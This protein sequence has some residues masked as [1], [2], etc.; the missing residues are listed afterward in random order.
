MQYSQQKNRHRWMSSIMLIILTVVTCSFQACTSCEQSSNFSS[1]SQKI[2]ESGGGGDGRPIESKPGSGTYYHFVP[3]LKCNDDLA[4]AGAIEVV[5]STLRYHEVDPTTCSLNVKE[6]SLEK[7]NWSSLNPE[8]LGHGSAIFQRQAVAPKNDPLRELNQVPIAESWCRLRNADHVVDILVMETRATREI[9]A[10]VMSSRFN[11][12]R[13]ESARLNDQAITRESDGD[14]LLYSMKIGA[15]E[16][17]RG[18]V[19]SSGVSRGQLAAMINGIRIEGV[20]DCRVGSEYD[21]LLP[22]SPTFAVNLGDGLLPSGL[23]L[24]RGSSATYFDVNGRI[25]VAGANSARMDFNPSTRE[26]RG[27]LLEKASTNLMLQ[28]SDWTASPWLADGMS[29]VRDGTFAGLDRFRVAGNDP[30]A[31]QIWGRAAQHWTINSGQAYALT[32]F[33][34]RGSQT[35]ARIFVWYGPG[36][37]AIIDYNLTNGTW[38]IVNQNVVSVR[39]VIVEPVGTGYRVGVVFESTTSGTMSLGIGPR[40]SV[41]GDYIYATGAQLEVGSSHSSYIPTTAS[42]ATRTEDALSIND[43]RW[44]NSARGTLHLAIAHQASATPAAQEIFSLSGGGG[45][46]YRLSFESS[47]LYRAEVNVGSVSRAWNSA[48][49]YRT[50]AGSTQQLSFAYEGNDAVLALNGSITSAAP[51]SSVLVPQILSI[52]GAGSGKWAG[53]LRSL[54]YWEQ[55]LP[56]ASLSEKTK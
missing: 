47:S 38:Q 50:D 6:V 45:D 7:I 48:N 26:P 17:N 19:D 31:T 9:S 30:A 41:V 43:L 1:S 39:S 4:H 14:K 8:F 28:S 36:S 52:G 22:T 53:H 12:G 3:G 24:T 18:I 51:G 10:T 46:F 35:S 13:W 5:G 27:L 55:R 15:L 20:M 37:E 40:S 25:A 21:R 49:V 54:T 2:D 44:F 23:M 11:G 32:F 56:N 29:V 33:A 34:E 42:T 16:I